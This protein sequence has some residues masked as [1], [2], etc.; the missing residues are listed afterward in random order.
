M[1]QKNYFDGIWN[2]YSIDCTAT[3]TSITAI[4]TTST[5]A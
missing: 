4:T 5:T 3:S 2:V 1:V